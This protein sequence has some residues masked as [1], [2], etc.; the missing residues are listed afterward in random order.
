MEEGTV[1]KKV[2]EDFIPVVHFDGANLK[3]IEIDIEKKYEYLKSLI[4]KALFNDSLLLI[5]IQNTFSY[6]FPGKPGGYSFC[7]PHN[8]SATFVD[9][10]DY[11]K[12]YSQE[13][14]DSEINN[15]RV[16]Y[17]DKENEKLNKEK[18][19]GKIDECLYQEA[20]ERVKEE[21]EQLV[22]DRIAEIKD[23]FVKKSI[24]YIQAYEFYSTLRQIKADEA[25]VMYSTEIIGWTKFNYSINKNVVVNFKSNF[26]Y[27]R[28][29]YFHIT[30][31]YKG[32]EIL[33]YP[34]LVQYF[35]ANMLD[36][37]DCTESY[38]P[39]RHNWEPALSFVVEQANWASVDE[40]A[41][42]Q[43]WII[44]GTN[45]MMLGLKE[46]LN[47]PNTAIDNIIKSN[48]DDSSLYSVRNITKDEIAEYEVYRHEMTIAFQ[49]EKI[50][51]SLLLIPNLTKLCSLYPKIKLIINEIES[52]NRKFFPQLHNAIIIISNKIKT[53]SNKIDSLQTEFSAFKRDNNR[54]FRD[55]DIFKKRNRDKINVFGDFIKD[56]PEFEAIYNKRNKYKKEI[57]E[58][59]I[60]L[61]RLSVFKEQLSRRAQLICDYGLANSFSDNYLSTS[62]SL[63]QNLLLV[64]ENNFNLSKSKRRLFKYLGSTSIK[65]IVI[66]DSIKVICDDSISGSNIQNLTLPL[67]LKKI[68]CCNFQCCDDLREIRIPDS[69]I[70]MGSDVFYRCKSLQKVYLS[71]SLEKIS[72][73]SF[74]KCTSLKNIA[75]PA[76]IK[77]IGRG[78][79]LD[80][81]SLQVVTLAN[82]IEIIEESAFKGCNSLKTIYIPIGTHEKFQRLL[83]AFK[84]M[85]VESTRIPI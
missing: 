45:E 53:L 60:E 14:F 77:T 76:P 64:T 72:S 15:V 27:G 20:I 28:S 59:S 63:A 46:I 41:F 73:F 71:N 65:E 75:I 34:K 44:D 40:D 7:F 30:L 57:E 70:E 3:Y 81:T 38:K 55:Y 24:R 68:G 61:N 83:P 69:V 16:G 49:A 32:V 10:A 6:I 78:A 31:I 42:V 18:E 35:H 85:L 50:S 29:A 17:I 33:S 9:S 67:G 79:F 56:H 84:N 82:S 36:F 37:I 2:N 5:E 1:S 25:N 43:K 47:F 39:E 13:E 4:N 11:P 48:I 8:Y 23:S 52:L 62:V 54:L 12:I 74:N 51:G 66:P 19:E 21:A 26:C 58:F 80:C 22:I